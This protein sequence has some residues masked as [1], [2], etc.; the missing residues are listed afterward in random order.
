[1]NIVYLL[2]DNLS[3]L[4]SNNTVPQKKRVEYISQSILKM[5][6][7]RENMKNWKEIEGDPIKCMLA[8]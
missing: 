7:W 5:F 3:S 8:C 6:A 4:L 2:H 1:M